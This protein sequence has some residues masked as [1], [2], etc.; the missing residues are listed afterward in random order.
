MRTRKSHPLTILLLMALSSVLL[1]DAQKHEWFGEWSM[2]HDGHTGMLHIS[3]SKVDCA[4]SVW[5][6]MVISYTDSQGRTYRGRIDGLN[7]RLQHMAF[8]ISFPGNTQKFD[9]Y[10]FS[11]DKT[12]LAGRTYWGGRTFGFYAL[13]K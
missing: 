9:A 8:S 5:C 2:N 12:K 1:A 3:D 4:T 11:W 10:I 7:D 13:K 6:D